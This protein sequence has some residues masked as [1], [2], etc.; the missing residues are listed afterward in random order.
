MFTRCLLQKGTLDFSPKCSESVCRGKRRVGK[1]LE[2]ES[3]TI[4]LGNIPLMFV[5]PNQFCNGSAYL[6]VFSFCLYTFG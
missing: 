4:L 6:D 2:G 3:V 1:D 5:I